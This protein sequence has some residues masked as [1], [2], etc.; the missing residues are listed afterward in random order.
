MLGRTAGFG[1]KP[2]PFT[3]NEPDLA[4]SR[5]FF[6]HDN[7]YFPSNTERGN[8]VLSICCI[9]GV[10]CALDFIKQIVSAWLDFSFFSPFLGTPEAF[11]EST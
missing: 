8:S 9:A 1:V 10:K 7:D 3:P 2:L 4:A 11:N 6:Y 5:F